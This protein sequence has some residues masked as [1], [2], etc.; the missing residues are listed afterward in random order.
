VTSTFPYQHS[1]THIFFLSALGSLLLHGLLVAGLAYLPT[2]KVVKDETAT[3]QVILLP[4]APIPQPSQAP[5]SP[6]QPSTVTHQTPP[7]HMPPMRPKLSQSPVP[8]LRASLKPP[9][10]MKLPPK[11]LPAL[12]NPILKDI[13]ASQA[14]KAR[15]LMKMRV[16][17]QVKLTAPFLSSDKT[18]Q[19]AVN[20]VMSPIPIVRKERSASFSLLA[21][22]TSAKLQALKAI[23]P[24]HSGPSITR[25]TLIS[26]NR[27][28]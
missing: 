27:R 13:H 8:P 18:R 15:D 16:P 14:M 11:L 26:S 10:T 1:E 25:P 19:N 24:G 20:L 7:P 5:T 2:S 4:T 3:V 28:S 12:A 6:L 22:P 9:P 17:T 21:P 23:P